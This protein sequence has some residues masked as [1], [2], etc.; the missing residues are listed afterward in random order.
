MCLE[1]ST[2]EPEG[3][4]GGLKLEWPDP[5]TYTVFISEGSDINLKEMYPGRLTNPVIP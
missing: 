3:K 2:L 1:S 5:S 4:E